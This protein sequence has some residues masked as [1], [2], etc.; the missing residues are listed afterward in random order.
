MSRAPWNS[1]IP[2]GRWS[3][4][5][6]DLGYDG[7]PFRW[8]ENRRHRLKCELDAIY[9]HMY[10]LDRSDLEHILDAPHPSASFPTLKRNELKQFGEYRTNDTFSKPTTRL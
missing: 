8:D 6:R 10:R 7:P 1:S 3:P 5:H 2:P 4:S 9:T